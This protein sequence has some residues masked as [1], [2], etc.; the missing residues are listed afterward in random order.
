[1]ATFQQYKPG[2][3]SVGSYQIAGVPYITGSAALTVGSEHHIVFPTVARSVQVVMSGSTTELRVH[4]N[5]TG[6]GNVVGGRHYI[7]LDSFKN[8]VTMNTRCK[9]IYVSS[10]AGTCDYTII[11]ELTGIETVDMT[12]ITGSGLTE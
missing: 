8:S 1:M 12:A 3:G 9:E 11:A 2:I 10:Q 5:P 6:S 4:F 7:V